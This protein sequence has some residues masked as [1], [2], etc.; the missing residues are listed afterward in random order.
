[1]TAPELREL[2]LEFPGAQ[3]EFPF[4]PGLSVF[5]VGA[6]MFALSPLAEAPLRV[7]V[8]CDPELG[9]QL[10][11]T[12]RSIQPGYHLNKR[13]WLTVLAD[14]STPDMLVA[15]LVSE[16]Y[17]LVVAALPR[18]VQRSLGFAPTR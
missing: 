1:M 15:D 11:A 4:R 9:Q 5:K 3:E 16:S 7:S 8:K 10:R 14:G 13:H 12:Y 2:C 17:E 18:A 6:K